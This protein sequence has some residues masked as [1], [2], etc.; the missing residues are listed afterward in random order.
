VKS[1]LTSNHIEFDDVDIS[2][3]SAKRDELVAA[4]YRRVP[5]VFMGDVFMGGVNEVRDYIKQSRD[6]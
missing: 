5:L 1:L 6:A 3:D 2:K 4:G